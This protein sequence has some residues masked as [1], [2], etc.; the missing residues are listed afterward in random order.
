[1]LVNLG[2][3]NRNNKSYM[4]SSLNKMLLLLDRR[5]EMRSLLQSL[6]TLECFQE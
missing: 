6:F 2:L 4:S 3:E 5:N 1:M